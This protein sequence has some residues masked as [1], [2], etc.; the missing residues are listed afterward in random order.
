MDSVTSQSLRIAPTTQQGGTQTIQQSIYLCHNNPCGQNLLIYQPIGY[1][2]IRYIDLKNYIDAIL[3]SEQM[4]ELFNE[5]RANGTIYMS[6]F[7]NQQKYY[8][9]LYS[10]M[11]WAKEAMNHLPVNEY[12]YPGYRFRVNVYDGSGTLLYDSY[13]PF[14]L[15]FYIDPVDGLY[16][17]TNVPILPSNPY[18]W[19]KTSGLY[20]I[21]STVQSPFIDTLT[22]IGFYTVLSNFLINQSQMQETVMAVSSLL[23]DSANTRTFGIPRYGFSARSDLSPF[24][25]IN[26]NCSHFIDITSVQTETEKTTLIES[27]FFRLSLEEDTHHFNTSARTPQDKIRILTELFN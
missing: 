25:G 5:I 8:K 6:D 12:E 27:I 9:Y 7:L 13:Y 16:K 24:G 17:K 11:V 21:S 4:M 2:K 18:S 26:Y 14:L 1:T 20:K 19:I 22:N 10:M 23:V 3:N 15:I